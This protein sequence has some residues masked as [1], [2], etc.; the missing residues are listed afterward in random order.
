MYSKSRPA[1]ALRQMMP[2]KHL[3]TPK[4]ATRKY[5][6]SGQNSFST[7]FST[8]NRSN[9]KTATTPIRIPGRFS[10]NEK[11][12]TVIQNFNFA[13][14]SFI[15]HSQYSTDSEAN[16]A[17]EQLYLSFDLLKTM[18]PKNCVRYLNQSPLFLKTM[19]TEG[20]L[21][22]DIISSVTLSL[23]QNELQAFIQNMT[24]EL[25]IFSAIHLC[26]TFQDAEE[27]ILNLIPLKKVIIWTKSDYSNFVYS[28]TL[29]AILTI[30]KS[31]VCC[32]FT[33][34]Q[35]IVTADP[36]D[37][38]GFNLDNDNPYLRHCKSMMLLPVYWPN[39]DISSIIQ[40]IGFKDPSTD[41]QIEF[42]TYYIEVLKIVRDILQKKFFSKIPDKVVP[43][44]IPSIFNELE[45]CSLSATVVQITKYLQN[46][47][48]CENVELFE[49]DDRTK[50]MTRLNDGT[51]YDEESGGVS[52]Q[53][54][55][56]QTPI[57]ISHSAAQET[58]KKEIDH[59]SSNKSVLSVSI[60]YHRQ[61]FVVTLR[62]K[63][64]EPAFNSL[65]SQMITSLTPIICDSLKLSKWLEKQ[66]DDTAKV[67]EEM[68]L[69]TVVND[70]LA[71]VSSNGCDR[72]EAIKK[73]AFQF[74][75]CDDLFV[76]LFDGRFMKF[77][78]SEV[79]CKFEE[80]TAG[81]AYNYRETVNGNPDDENSK[82]N[83]KLYEELKVDCKESIAFPY[84]TGG[85]V[86]G[87]IELINPGQKN[88]G[89][90]KQKLF[91]NLCAC[92]LSN[93]HS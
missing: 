4:S 88:I 38:P 20:R 71:L 29:R 53:A 80:C 58:L 44:N 82:F 85:R 25:N 57:N 17:R 56:S 61:H 21:D 46:E 64:N 43:S 27:Q 54:A 9:I 3:A 69:M 83:S 24:Q 37:H 14:S 52:Y 19:F 84:R 42:N 77:S 66:A 78:P 90:D 13:P 89:P 73:A 81:T 6:K 47:V 15:D 60:F 39:G 28:P 87:A 16:Q 35:D 72:W 11:N 7:S 68:K 45:K 18:T 36:G 33:E 22:P 26:E 67:K 12:E 30:G 62:G 1:T 75:E 86:A 41:E 48:P 32:P 79:K 59:K 76:A 70:T 63:P 51:T 40:C 23:T 34:K 93:S 10:I 65:D 50:I 2:Q 49:F 74:F 91:S 5:D 55:L 8:K 31:I 92:L